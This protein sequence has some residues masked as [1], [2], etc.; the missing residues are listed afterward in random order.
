MNMRGLLTALTLFI[1]FMLLSGCGSDDKKTETAAQGTAGAACYPNGTCNQG[2]KCETD[3]CVLA[4]STGPGSLGGACYGNGTCNAG[5]ECTGNL[6]MATGTTDTGAGQGDAGYPC[7]G[8]NTCNG[9]LSCYNNL[10]VQ[11]GTDSQP[12]IPADTDSGTSITTATDSEQINPLVACQTCMATNCA[13]QLTTC[14][15]SAPCATASSCVLTCQ[16]ET[17]VANCIPANMAI[18]DLTALT[19]IGD[20]LSTACTTQCSPPD[21]DSAAHISDSDTLSTDTSVTDTA[22]GITQSTDSDSQTPAVCTAAD[23]YKGSCATGN[24]QVCEAGQ[25]VMGDC[26]GCG[27]VSPSA[28]AQCEFLFPLTFEQVSSD[29]LVSTEPLDLVFSQ[30]ASQVNAEWALDDDQLGSIQ[31]VFSGAVDPR[32]VYITATGDVETVTLETENGVSGCQY[33]LSHY[34]YGELERFINGSWEGCWGV[35]EDQPW[36][37]EPVVFRY[38][39]IRTYAT[40]SSDDVTISITEID[41][42]Y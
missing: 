8:N 22:T 1:G 20:C 36:D 25:W 3:L 26:S 33:V 23:G 39:N 16:D 7:Y 24:L 12:I 34:S 5:L 11:L 27:V 31:F 9:T 2:L 28:T 6:C 38:M 41:L 21:S 15:A 18:A 14:Q 13:T 19:A 4:S 37:E 35:Y 30:T 32:D 10:C 42:D 29:E 40:F 17:C